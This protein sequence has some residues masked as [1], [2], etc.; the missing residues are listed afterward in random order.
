[1]AKQEPKVKPTNQNSFTI[2]AYHEL[3]GSCLLL[4]AP[5]DVRN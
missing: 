1:M 4:F 5:L 3:I 2:L